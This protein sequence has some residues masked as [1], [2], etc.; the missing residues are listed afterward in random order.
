LQTGVFTHVGV[1]IPVGVWMGSGPHPALWPGRGVH[2]GVAVVAA[3]VG[4]ARRLRDRVAV[5]VASGD[6][7]AV[8]Q[9]VKSMVGPSA[10]Q[11]Q[12]PVA[13]SRTQLPRRWFTTHGAKA[14][15]VQGRSA[16]VGSGIALFAVSVGVRRGGVG[17]GVMNPSK[18]QL[19]AGLAPGVHVFVGV[20][21]AFG[22]AQPTSAFE[23]DWTKQETCGSPVTHA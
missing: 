12:A 15:D 1:A 7:V 6:G 18:R 19:G 3:A 11:V 4:H 9:R 21:D 5:T 17:V 8:A 20:A 13:S 23:T 10:E 22:D 2:V 16:S 14:H